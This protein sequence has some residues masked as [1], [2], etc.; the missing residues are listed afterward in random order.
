MDSTELNINQ[1]SEFIYGAISERAKDY[2]ITVTKED[3]HSVVKEIYET[4]FTVTFN[5]KN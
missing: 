5:I 3:V 2:N 4:E 1:I